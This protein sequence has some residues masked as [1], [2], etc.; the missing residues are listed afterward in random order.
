M[1]QKIQVKT[2]TGTETKAMAAFQADAIS[3]A[4]SGYTPTSQVWAPGRYGAGAFLL[5]LILSVVFIGIIIFIYMLIVKPPGILTVTYARTD[6][7]ASRDMDAS[8]SQFAT[9]LAESSSPA[10]ESLHVRRNGADLGRLDLVTI[11]Q[12]LNSGRLSMDD[13]YYS[14]GYDKW[15]SLD[16]H[17]KL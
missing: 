8:A 15:R 10:A 12:M 14:E 9:R 11:K 4:A 6:V 5:A 16:L 17:P 2:Y 7:P 13:L 3:M 1:T